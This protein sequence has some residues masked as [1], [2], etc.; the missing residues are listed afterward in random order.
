MNQKQEPCVGQPGSNALPK[1]SPSSD[2][3]LRT[4]STASPAGCSQPT[5]AAQLRKSTFN[6]EQ[7]LNRNRN[8]FFSSL[9]LQIPA[10][11][12]EMI[13]MQRASP[14]RRP[15]LMQKTQTL[16]V[17]FY[18]QWA[19]DTGCQM[20]LLGRNDVSSGKTAAEEWPTDPECK[21]HCLQKQFW[22][23]G[24]WGP[25]LCKSYRGHHEEHEET[26]HILTTQQRS[27]PLEMAL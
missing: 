9:P 5:A 2:D 1:S 26:C 15:V 12:Q 24:Y 11:P 8:P 23:P 6:T 22:R 10:L 25:T 14:A 19:P 16:V 17:A 20:R 4:R 21:T 27:L 7:P 18:C 13:C 3:L